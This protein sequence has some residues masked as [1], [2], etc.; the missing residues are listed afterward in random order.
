MIFTMINKNLELRI[1]KY[2]ID[3]KRYI[4]QKYNENMMILKEENY[5]LSYSLI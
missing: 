4:N 3:Q 5:C 1:D 2:N